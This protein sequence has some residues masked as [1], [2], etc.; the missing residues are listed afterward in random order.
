MNQEI[1]QNLW[2]LIW[3]VLLLKGDTLRAINEI[4][5]SITIALIIVLVAGLSQEI[6]QCI[7]LFVNRVQPI[8]FIFSLLIGAILFTF[9]YFFLV[10][11]SW[12]I[13]LTPF[14]GEENVSFL[15]I[16]QVI[17]FSYVP[18]I[19][20]FLGAMPYLGVPILSLL[21]VWHLLAMVV[22]FAAV[23]YLSFKQ[24]IIYVFL[25]WLVLQILQ[26]TIGQPLANLA[27][28][29][30]NQTA[31]V[32]LSTNSQDILRLVQDGL[33]A[34]NSPLKQNGNSEQVERDQIYNKIF[35]SILQDRPQNNK[36][37]NTF[38]GLLGIGLVTFLVITFAEP[39][40]V[41]TAQTINNLPRTIRWIYDLIWI[42][43]LG[44]VIAGLLAPLETL[45]WWA[46]WYNDEID[47]QVNVGE[48]AQPLGTNNKVSRYIIYLDG[49]GQ[50]SFQYL[51]DVEL[52][53]Q[54]LTER[55]PKDMALIRGIMPY[56]VLNNPLDED[57]PLAFFW[58]IA[59]KLRFK[60]PASILGMIVN[61]RNVLTVAVSA[62]QRYGLI[63][64][65]G[66][67]QVIYN[68]LINHGYNPKEATPITLIGY[69]G[70]GQM[71]A[72]SAPFL[73]RSLLGS[74]EVISLGGVISG[75]CNL[76]KLDHLYHLVGDKDSVERLG[77]IMFAG[78]WKMFPLSYWNRAKR[79]G[80]VTLMSLGPVGHQV[81]G[82]MMD[83]QRFLADGRSYLE[84]TLEV[85]LNILRGY[86]QA[87]VKPL[88]VK[89]SNYLRY[90]E[91]VFNCNESYPVEQNLP[92]HWY[93]PQGEWMGRLILPQ[94]EER[95]GVR[96]VYWEVYHA[97]AAYRHLVGRVIKLRLSR[98]IPY[99]K[100]VTKDV[101]FSEEAFYTQESEGL[102]HPIR[103]EQW[104]EVNPL[105]SLAGSHPVDDV[106]VMLPAAG[107]H[108]QD[109]DTLVINHEP[110]Q[111]T[112]RFYALV[113]FQQK[114]G[115]EAWSVRHFNVNSQSFDGLEAKVY[116]PQVIAD[117][118]GVYPS[119]SQ[120]IEHSAFNREGW[121]IYGTQDHQGR[122]IIQSWQPRALHRLN[123][124][125]ILFGFQ[126][127]WRYLRSETWRNLVQKKGSVESVLIA[128]SALADNST[129]LGKWREG[130]Y[131]LVIHIYGGIG[132][133]KAEPATST[134]IYFGHFAYGVAQVVREPLSAEL[135]FRI[136]YY[137]VYTHNT[138]GLIAGVLDSSRYLGDR[139]FGWLGTRPTQ[140][141]LIKFPPFTEDLNL[142]GEKVSGLRS[143][144]N[145]LEAMTAR[146]RIGDGTGATY[147][148]PASNCS[149][150]SN[151]ALFAS[152]QMTA[153]FMKENS[154]WLEEWLGHHPEN[155]QPLG[156]LIKLETKL[157][158][159]L[160]FFGKTRADWQ[161]DTYSLGS[162]LEDEPL[163]NLW[164]GLGSWRTIFPRLAS[165]TIVK[166]FLEAG[167]SVWVLRTNQV[168]GLAP[169]IEPVA[170]NTI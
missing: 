46:G 24:A 87:Q 55:L 119:S 155:Q 99:L 166:I 158:R 91:G 145:Q 115:E 78:R 146:Y 49:I 108:V 29:L 67:A 3:D 120:K 127:G 18:L 21:A 109:E 123:P 128:P 52:F 169:E 32:N 125:K 11:S 85:I 141:L 86:P 84:Q 144:I 136:I 77:P 131:A 170:P 153:N 58:R 142:N 70:G 59:D 51:P 103:L 98:T 48:L 93:L 17:G 6:G 104:R 12:L 147:V 143:M 122:F 34:P 33:Q 4:P 88:I 16:A 148:G 164:M 27:R 44:I 152:L 134:P 149:Q 162:T 106:V 61:I 5:A 7:I 111:I 81:P 137:Q 102:I 2:L 150:D 159:E 8:R 117:I 13:T 126:T 124:D 94:R 35:S 25:G 168:G 76:L 1:W 31:G 54:A 66:I 56:S 90:R 74:I 47:T 139:Q 130:D 57:R 38:L 68:A 45:G 95:E 60:N 112:G 64:N 26:A 101:H 65:Q 89:S 73:K 151:R 79:R 28:W 39:I 107:V 19:F 161:K 116:L 53:L 36:F 71:S 83:S 10:I 69:S 140:D 133:E 82:G 114:L 50:S 157:R 163:R 14:T 135:G 167:A 30:A 63:Y 37:L 62:D 105:E 72:A 15:T 160:Q 121:Y 43:I 97:P 22:G 41:G 132:G 80:K 110:I 100:A 92:N 20:S 156:H 113:Q 96:G 118:Y 75:N 165:D 23:T 42:G 129:A 40:S 138:D 154:S 9:G